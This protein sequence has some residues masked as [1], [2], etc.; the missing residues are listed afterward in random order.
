[1][2]Q[3]GNY[4]SKPR[5]QVIAKRRRAAR[6]RRTPGFKRMAPP[7]LK[8]IPV[9]VMSSDRVDLPWH[10]SRQLET[11]ASTE[12]FF[13]HCSESEPWEGTKHWL[14]L[15]NPK[16]PP[17]PKIDFYEAKLTELDA[18]TVYTEVIDNHSASWAI[19]KGISEALFAVMARI[20]E[21]TIVSS[22][23]EVLETAERQSGLAIKMWERFVSKG[24]AEYNEVSGRYVYLGS[25][26][27]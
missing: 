26:G 12:P 16:F 9:T 10:P 17:D 11:D 2:R 18:G 4:F 14:F 21:L 13:W 1:M 8:F 27:Y 7:P 22:Q 23:R 5:R 25:G 24:L 15:V 20:L 6:S 19:G 3:Q